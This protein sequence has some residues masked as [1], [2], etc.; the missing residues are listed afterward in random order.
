MTNS[1]FDTASGDH[2]SCSDTDEVSVQTTQNEIQ[3]TV[4]ASC[5]LSKSS[6]WME[7]QMKRIMDSHQDVWGH[8]L[9]IVRSEQKCA[10]AKD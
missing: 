3:K 10:L 6:D 8:D 4:R 2:L 9:A 5:K 7:A 1:D